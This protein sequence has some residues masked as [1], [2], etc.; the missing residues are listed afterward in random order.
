MYC[1]PHMTRYA[2][3]APACLRAQAWALA[4]CTAPSHLV[5][6]R[7]GS[8]TRGPRGL[9]RGS[10]G[11]FLL[12]ASMAADALVATIAGSAHH[13]SRRAQ[14]N[15]GRVVYPAARTNPH[16]HATSSIFGSIS[17]PAPVDTLTLRCLRR[18]PGRAPGP[19]RAFV[20]SRDRFTTASSLASIR[21]QAARM[22]KRPAHC[23][24]Q[25]KCWQCGLKPAC[26]RFARAPGSK[27][28][29]SVMG[30][31]T[32]AVGLD[33]GRKTGYLVGPTV[34][35]TNA[36]AERMSIDSRTGWREF[37]RLSI[38]ARPQLLPDCNPRHVV[39]RRTVVSESGS[40]MYDTN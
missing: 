19:R 9:C 20:K 24:H 26:A 11:S 1:T 13:A 23:S 18:N 37:W 14:N 33:Q 3:Q 22:G 10:T 21:E 39:L 30:T 8:C 32:R 29:A 15:P 17:F 35:V 16:D 2:P 27:Y 5:G 38:P 25:D 31:A 34:A 36:R 4:N 28:Y 7:E 6:L 40:R 12:H